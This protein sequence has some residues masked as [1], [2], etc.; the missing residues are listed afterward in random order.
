MKKLL[1]SAVAL[2]LALTMT[3]ACQTPGAD[4]EPEH[5]HTFEEHWS[6]DENDHWHEASCEH[7]DQLS[8]KA[9]HEDQDGND[10]CDVC[11]YHKEHVHTY[12]EQWTKGE[13]THYKKNTCGHDD[14][15]KYRKDEADHEDKNNDG[16]CDVCAYDYGH[17]HTYAE[18]WT[19]GD[20]GHWHAP[21][22]GHDVPGTDLTDHADADNDGI[23][24]TCGYD[25]DHTHTYADAWSQSEDEH[26]H[27]VTCGHT[28]PVADK[29]AHV[30]ADHN[31]ECDICGYKPEHFHTFEEVWSADANGHYHKANC[32]HD[33]KADEQP[34]NGYEQDGLCDAC[35]YEVFHLYTV[36]VTL[37]DDSFKVTAPD[38]T[39]TP[40]FTVKEGTDA[41]FTVTLPE[42]LL[43]TSADGATIE[44]K[45][46]KAD[47]YRTYTL[48]ISA[49]A[50]DLT[51]TLQLD[52]TSNVEVVVPAGKYEMEITKAWQKLTGTVTFHAPASGR[53]IV[54]SSSHAGLSGVTF[55]LADNTV[56]QNTT[57]ISYAFDVAAEGDVTLDWTYFAM[58]V[59]EGGK[60][61]FTYVIAKIDPEKVLDS[62]EGEGY[63]MPTNADVK[64]TFTVPEPGLYRIT[65]SYPVAW[66]GDVTKPHV[67]MVS[68]GALT[69]SLMLHYHKETESSFPFDWKIEKMSGTTPVGMGDTTVT[70]PVD[71]YYGIEFTAPSDGSYYFSVSDPQMALYQWYSSEYWSSMNQVGTSWT[72]EDVKKGDQVILYVR[73]NI[74]DDDIT[75]AIEGVL[76]I[77]YVPPANDEG[78]LAQVGSENIFVSNDYQDGEYTITLPAGGQISVDGG[79]T[80][81]SGVDSL[82]IPGYGVLE[83]LVKGDGDTVVVVFEKLEYNVTLAVGPN[84]VSLIPGKEYTF[85][86]TGTAS[87]DYHVTYLLHWTDAAIT[88]TYGG[89]TL[90]TGATIDRY[91][92]D[93]S[94]VTV[95]YNGPSKAD[96]AFTLEDGYVVPGIDTSMLSGKYTVNFMSNPEMYIVTFTPAAPGALNGTLTVKDN[97]TYSNKR[98]NGDFLYAYAPATGVTVTTTDGEAVDIFISA[99]TNGNLTFQCAG[100]AKPQ[101][102]NPAT[103][104]GGDENETPD[105]P[106]DPLPESD[107]K[108]GENAVSIAAA[109]SETITFTATEAGTYTFSWAEGETNGD[110]MVEIDYVSESLYFPHTVTLA[111]GESFTFMLGTADWAADTIDFVITKAA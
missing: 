5:V 106:E 35:G 97:N 28:I 65:S 3:T 1:M 37:P 94:T 95:V 4:K 67:F 41:T 53:Y 56:E 6:G 17:T 30:D 11:G 88:V 60:E 8:E 86:L 24:D 42:R 105:M 92:P 77:G 70:A 44:G 107:I 99:N 66:D 69:Q 13:N 72:A 101:V 18:E 27:E 54:Y 78:Y 29:N 75:D 100:L 38:G 52:K 104:A 48:K 22:C 109:G 19:E 82:A 108:V 73:V 102:L 50:A 47:G 90:A 12:E 10:V 76:S 98:F 9:P 51:I 103:P 32:G 111:A 14:V 110:A 16:L 80:W 7:E 74:Y 34:H 83:Y 61:T 20:G 81:L 46:T 79:Q 39:V 2:M 85:T 23:C 31:K 96:I 68:E 62:M 15:E 84:T 93:S 64:I 40:T 45:P 87:P 49:I 71:N 36:T 43:I 91:N 58:S 21:T 63:T 25:Y 33:A 55:H 26:W 59:P 89:Q 57:G